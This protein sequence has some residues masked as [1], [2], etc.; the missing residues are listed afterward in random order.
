MY[1]PRLRDWPT[2]AES[3]SGLVRLT[4]HPEVP[5]AAR[6]LRFPRRANQLAVDE[7]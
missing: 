5:K 2:V 4:A 6:V 3:C 1:V 7:Q